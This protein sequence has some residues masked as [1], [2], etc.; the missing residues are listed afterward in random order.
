MI[1]TITLLCFLAAIILVA[2]G[3]K[4][5]SDEDDEKNKEGERTEKDSETKR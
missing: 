5:G 1:E 3:G 2:T 4:S